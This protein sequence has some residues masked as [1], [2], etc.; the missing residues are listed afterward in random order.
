[1]RHSFETHEKH[2]KYSEATRDGT[3]AGT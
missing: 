2:S 1:M 3:Y